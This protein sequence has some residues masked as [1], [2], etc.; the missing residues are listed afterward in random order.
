MHNH[1]TFTVKFHKDQQTDAAR[2]VGFEVRPFR[3]ILNSSSFSIHYV[4]LSTT[5]L[6]FWLS[7]WYIFVGLV[8]S[9]NMK[10]NGVKQPV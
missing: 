1:L 5:V 6:I 7:Y 8:L 9:M 2:I 4:L 10:A 3:Y